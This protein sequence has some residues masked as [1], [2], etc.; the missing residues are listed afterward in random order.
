ML[1]SDCC[2][3]LPAGGMEEYGICGDC[4]E[5]C[6]FY[7]DEEPEMRDCDTAATTLDEVCEKAKRLK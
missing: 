7:D 6:E 5:H 1:L 2:G 3:A 4:K